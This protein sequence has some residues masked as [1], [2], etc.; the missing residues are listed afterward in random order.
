M[1]NTILRPIFYSRCSLRTRSFGLRPEH[2]LADQS[3]ALGYAVRQVD[4][5]HGDCRTPHRGPAF[6]NWA[7]P[8]EMA[9]PL[10]AARVKQPNFPPCSGIN[11][12]QVRS[13]VVV[14]RQTG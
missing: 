9:T 7:V 10:M 14:A 11:A 8:P 4:R 1:S 6:Q 13:L 2:A 5:Q 3:R 12:A